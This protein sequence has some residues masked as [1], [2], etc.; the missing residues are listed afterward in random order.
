MLATASLV[1]GSVLGLNGAAP[2]SEKLSLAHI[3]ISGQGRRDLDE[4]AK[5]C[6]VAAL[7]DVDDRRASATY[8][9]YP[10]ARR[11]KDFRKM[12]DEV[13]K[14]VDGV[15]VATPNHTHAVAAMR[16]ISA[17]STAPVAASR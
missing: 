2:P 15:V 1:P 7:C 3:G 13:G 9:D 5:D 14:D 17:A 10:R 6:N 8:K 16:N 11:F 4:L 12:L